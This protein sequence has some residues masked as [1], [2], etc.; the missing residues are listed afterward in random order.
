MRE[1]GFSLLFGSDGSVKFSTACHPL[2]ISCL[3]HKMFDERLN[4]N[5]EALGS[6]KIRITTRLVQNNLGNTLFNEF[7]VGRSDLDIIPDAQ[8]ML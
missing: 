1:H 3:V 5:V 6:S 4:I 2:F 7:V 8:Q